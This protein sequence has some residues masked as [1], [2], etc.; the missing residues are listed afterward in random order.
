MPRSPFKTEHQVRRTKYL[1]EQH[2]FLVQ[3]QPQAKCAVDHGLEPI[4]GETWAELQARLDEVAYW[5]E[6]HDKEIATNE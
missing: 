5:E 6:Q 1:T 3:T 2:A 4:D